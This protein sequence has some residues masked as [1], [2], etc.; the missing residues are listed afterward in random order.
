MSVKYFTKE[1]GP[2]DKK[3]FITTIPKSG[4]YLL[5]EIVKQLGFIYSGVFLAPTHV[6]DHRQADQ[7]VI[8]TRPQT[9]FF[10]QPFSQSSKLI[11]PG[12]YAMGHMPYCGEMNNFSVIFGTRNLRDVIVSC[13][14]Y[15]EKRQDLL[16][17]LHQKLWDATEMSSDKVKLWFEFWGEEYSILIKKLVKSWNSR[18]NAFKIHFENITPKT[19]IKLSEY[20][21]CPVSEERAQEILD[22]ATNASTPTRNK[23]HTSYE[24]Y[25]DDETEELF[26]KFGF[27]NVT[28]KLEKQ[29]T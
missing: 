29:L 3:V 27:F 26:K 18:E 15:Y 17:T 1:Q 11:L 12:Q 10:N 28:V 20:L 16:A 24:D 22:A 8:R 7:N 13:T 25:W 6:E 5:G 19:V 9:Y 23:K 21:D 4:T 14:R 2:S